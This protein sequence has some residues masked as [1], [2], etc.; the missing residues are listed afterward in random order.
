MYNCHGTDISICWT[1]RPVLSW[2]YQLMT[3]S[4]RLAGLKYGQLEMSDWL[5]DSTGNCVT[6]Q[7]QMTYA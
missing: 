4:S 3:Q 5:V 2:Y 6:A 1:H 7:Y